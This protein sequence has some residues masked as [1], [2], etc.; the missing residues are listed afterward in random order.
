MN[1]ESLHEIIIAWKDKIS[2]QKELAQTDIKT[3][4]YAMRTFWK[5]PLKTANSPHKLVN[6]L[7][8]YKQ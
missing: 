1:L 7:I 5:C 8:K 3:W 2:L 6:F 4:S